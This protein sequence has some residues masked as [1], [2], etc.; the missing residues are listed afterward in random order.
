MY[1]NQAI[2]LIFRPQAYSKAATI[3]MIRKGFTLNE[4]LKLLRD[5]LD[6]MRDQFM[7]KT[8][9]LSRKIEALEKQALAS[10]T[11]TTEQE[12][13]G[14]DTQADTSL[15]SDLSV[16]QSAAAKTD[17][18]ELAPSQMAQLK[19]TVN[20]DIHLDQQHQA[21]AKEHKPSFIQVFLVQIAALIFDWFSPLINIY[22]NYK[23]RGMLGI[24][25][26]TIAGA[27]L[28][29]AG[30]G[31]L[32]QLLI[33]EMGAGL[34]SLLMSATAASVVAGGLVLK[35]KTKLAEFASAIV[36]LGLLL[37]F[38]TVYFVGSVYQLIPGLPVLLLYAALALACHYLALWLDTKVIAVLGIV[39]I[40]VMPLLSAATSIDPTYYVIALLCVSASSLYLAYKHI[41]HWLAELT[42]T[43]AFV[44][45]GWIDAANAVFMS[46]WMINAFYLLFSAYIAYNLFMHQ[47]PAKRYLV[48]QA[49]VLGGTLVLLLQGFEY[50]SIGALYSSKDVSNAFY[51][52][53]NFQLLINAALSALLAFLF[54]RVKHEHIALMVLVAAT[55]VVLSIISLLE[56]TYWGIAWAVEALLLIF[57]SRHY[58]LPSL[59]HQGQ[60]LGALAFGYCLLALIPYFPAPALQSQDGWAIVLVIMLLVAFWQRVIKTRPDAEVQYSPYVQARVYPLLVFIEAAWLSIVLLSCAYIWL[61]GWAGLSAVFVQIAL[62]FRSRQVNSTQANKTLLELLAC[63]LVLFPLAYAVMGSDAVNS[64]RFSALPLYAKASLI[65]AF[66]Q[67]WLWSAFYRKFNPQSSLSAIAE[68]ARILFYLLLPVIWLPTLY[69]RL[70]DDIL[71]LLWLSPVLA[72]VLAHLTKAK[73]L[74]M[75]SKLLFVAL[76]LLTLWLLAQNNLLVSLTGIVGYMAAVGIS[77]ALNKRIK[78]PE[79]AD[80]L[81]RWSINS[82][83]LNTVGLMLAITLGLEFDSLL[84]PLIIVSL[85]SIA[86]IGAHQRFALCASN[87]AFH[88]LYL[89]IASVSS[90]QLLSAQSS[91]AGLSGVYHVLYV[92]SP[93]LI[94]L[95]AWIMKNRGLLPFNAKQKTATQNIELGMHTYLLITYV[96]TCLALDYYAMSL[97][98]APLLAV[99]GAAI[100]FLKNRTK[101]TVR[102][103]FGLIL[104]GI[105]KLALIDTANVVLWQKVMLFIGIGVFILF[106]S[107]WYQ[108]L[109]SK[110][111]EL[112]NAQ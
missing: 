94:L 106:A 101:M 65:L 75:Q 9:L 45:L 37:G 49:A 6:A 61:D 17:T 11:A 38:S 73:P 58:K 10:N 52:S 81:K 34:K 109:V 69:R 54:F 7:L 110:D 15:T 1:V 74:Y 67:L 90:W 33:D 77:F 35:V 99:H 83:A 76:T 107:F 87:R 88:L 48:L 24:F 86:V 59:I 96:L 111:A 71:M 100:L 25:F 12:N 60:S 68:R 57:M 95:S 19:Q 16:N 41:G 53:I 40:S 46:A 82:W 92:I 64:M 104:L 42:F 55:W 51:N 70:D 29:L 32:M 72:M 50:Q 112:A 14:S 28:V 66:V 91:G 39:G 97:A 44:A 85:F 26:L 62:L 79:S 13:T 20:T 18:I 103:S 80:M 47:T 108:K 22:E 56:A 93:V 5:E 102:Y 4:Q 43:F 2:S 63:S 78:N 8:M 31:Y 36:A 30:F 21:P 3:G 98:V 84:I 23:A 105:A 27:G 89:A